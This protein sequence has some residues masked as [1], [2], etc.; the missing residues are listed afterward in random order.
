M[1][2]QTELAFHPLADVFPLIEGVEFDELVASIKE[3]GLRHPI[4][5]LDDMIL[6]GRNRYRACLAAGVAPLRQISNVPLGF[7]ATAFAGEM[8]DGLFLPDYRFP[9]GRIVFDDG[10]TSAWHRWPCMQRSGGIS[11]SGGTHRPT[12]RTVA[13]AV[14]VC[15][16]DKNGNPRYAQLAIA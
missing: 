4:T 16:P 9:M 15:A 8:R 12:R 10:G 13:I 7:D 6:D 3:H 1:P 11:Y 14:E 5:T 2:V